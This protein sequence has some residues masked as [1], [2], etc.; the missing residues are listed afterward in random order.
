MMTEA[1]R[2]A[3]LAVS[4]SESSCMRAADL[5]E[6]H[7]LAKLVNKVSHALLCRDVPRVTGFVE[8]DAGQVISPARY[9]N[10]NVGS[11]LHLH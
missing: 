1:V 5:S 3:P 4:R 11:L 2:T 9:E 10:L 7:A 8:T 6:A